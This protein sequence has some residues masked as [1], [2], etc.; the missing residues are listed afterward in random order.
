M[1]I[2]N[3]FLVAP[4]SRADEFWRAMAPLREPIKAKSG[5]ESCHIYREI[6]EGRTFA[7]IQEW[8][9][10]KALERYIRSK[11]FTVILSLIDTSVEPPKIQ[12]VHADSA[13]GLEAIARVREDSSGE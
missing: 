1:E 10:R 13:E 2:F 11:E 12:I 4:K 9:D 7:L 3:L 6:G 8:K 5:C